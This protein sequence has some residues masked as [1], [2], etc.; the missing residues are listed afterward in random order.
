MSV[1]P[2]PREGKAVE[3]LVAEVGPVTPLSVVCGHDD[4]P[5]KQKNKKS[6]REGLIETRQNKFE[7]CIRADRTRTGVVY[8]FTLN[9][10]FYPSVLFLRAREIRAPC[11]RGHKLEFTPD[12]TLRKNKRLKFFLVST[13]VRS[14]LCF[15]EAQ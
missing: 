6:S 9:R 13:P 10:I 12:G 2:S 11:S 7:E 8:F 5:A 14:F 3:S 4:E 1:H 15:I